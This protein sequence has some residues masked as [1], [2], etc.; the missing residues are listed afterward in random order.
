MRMLASTNVLVELA[1]ETAQHMVGLRCLDVPSA[2]G[3]GSG[4]AFCKP[5]CYTDGNGCE[6]S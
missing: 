2:Q 3:L 1:C 6:L 5:A 4:C